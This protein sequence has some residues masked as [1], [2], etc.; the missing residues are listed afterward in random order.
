MTKINKKILILVVEDEKVLIDTLEEKLVSE[1]FDV[2]KAYDGDEGLKLALAEHP[3]LILLDILMPKVDGLVMLKKLREDS[4][5]KYANVMILTNVKDTNT[6]ADSM[7][8][9]LGGTG[10]TYEYIV[11]TDW[12][13]ESIIARIK[14]KLKI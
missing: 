12:S 8:I 7:E 2:T 11:K 5:G 4:W 14:N 9:E 6:I 13:L 1:G 3:D 10:N